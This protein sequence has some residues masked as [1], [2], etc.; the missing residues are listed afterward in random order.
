MTQR[1]RP[2][3]SACWSPTSR[4]TAPHSQ[5]V[6][7]N[8]PAL[9]ALVILIRKGPKNVGALTGRIP[10]LPARGGSRRP[11]GGGQSA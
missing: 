9:T 3:T 10:T 11:G 7:R 1:R 5:P 4:V 6:E 2:R 8:Q